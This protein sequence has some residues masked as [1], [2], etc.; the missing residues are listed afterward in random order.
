M[1]S[2]SL[3]TSLCPSKKCFGLTDGRNRIAVLTVNFATVS[4][5]LTPCGPFQGIYHNRWNA[6]FAKVVATRE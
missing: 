3:R 5:M 2:E 4:L 1:G 6:L